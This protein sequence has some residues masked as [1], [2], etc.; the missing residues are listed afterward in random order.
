IFQPFE[1]RT[2]QPNAPGT[3]IGLAL[4]MQ[5]A[6]LHGGRVEVGERHGGGA[7]FRVLLPTD[8]RTQPKT[9][10]PLPA[11]PP[12]RLVEPISRGVAESSPG[13]A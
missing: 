8:H 5:F 12:A 2:A 4:V 11:H 1:R 10:G 9:G 6:E 7:S 13:T 3:G